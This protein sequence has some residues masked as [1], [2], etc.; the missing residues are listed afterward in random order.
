MTSGLSAGGE[1]CSAKEI[2][3][4][5]GVD[6]LCFGGTKNG[7]VAAELV[8]FFKK[9]L[10][11]EFEYRVKQTGQLG[12]K[13]RFLA[14]QWHALLRN[15][16]WLKNARHA[17]SMAREFTRQMRETAKIDT[18]LPVE[19]NA[20]FVRLASPLEEKLRSRGWHFYKFIEP[21]VYRLMCSWATRQ[22]EI[23]AFVSDLLR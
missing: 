15:E 13:R 21:D 2:T 18:V 10:S 6:V 11:R 5:S 9:D 17:N 14:A 19:A 1:R 16:V 12:S 20:V 22:E 3:W 8:V 7:A 4:Q 23:D